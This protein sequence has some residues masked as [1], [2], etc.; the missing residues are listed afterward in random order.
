MEVEKRLKEL[1]W[2]NR[3]LPWHRGF[4]RHPKSEARYSLMNALTPQSLC[5]LCG[6]KPPI[7]HS[8]GMR[9]AGVFDARED[10]PR[11]LQEL[12][13][14]DVSAGTGMRRVP[15][16][17]LRWAPVLM[18][19]AAARV[20][21]AGRGLLSDRWLLAGPGVCADLGL[22]SGPLLTLYSNAAKFLQEY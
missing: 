18:Q 10:M 16:T 8:W 5:A 11:C 12:S 21:L 7:G 22:F 19:L 1:L 14:Q 20:L 9:F 4:A 3:N 17:G 6:R 13:G 15:G 2:L